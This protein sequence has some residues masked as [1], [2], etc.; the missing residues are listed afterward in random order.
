MK[1]N[2]GANLHQLSGVLGIE[3]N[4]IIDFSS[5]INPFGLSP[6]GLEKLKNNLNLASIYPDPEYIEL[7]NS[8]ANY[9]NCNANNIVLGSGATELI[10]STIKVI[11]PKKALLLSPAYSEY[12]KEL[13]RIEASITKFFYKKENNFKL[14]IDEIIELITKEEFDMIV[15][16]NPN[17]PTGTLIS[18]QEIEEIYK[19][20]QKPI[21]IDETYIEFTESSETSAINLVQKYDKIIVIRGTSKFFSTPGI[22]LGYAIISAGDILN[23]MTLIPNLWNINI[24]AAIMGEAMFSDSDYIKMC[25]LNFLENFTTLYE[26]LKSFKDFKV[27]DSKS[28]FILCEILNPKYDATSL[29]NF[30]LKK[31]IIIR[32]AESFDGLNSNFFRVCV[33]TKENIN[34]LLSEIQKFILTF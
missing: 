7:K 32:K 4:A 11:N 29:Y 1:S 25:H 18:I 20:F 31:G 22:R 34:L 5:N 27:Y 33:L 14:N 6:K 30:L 19:A 21:M 23:T 17:N 10:A 26:G 16:C 13:N 8:I 28:N 3:Q 12:E 9:C 2:H 15:I 24:F